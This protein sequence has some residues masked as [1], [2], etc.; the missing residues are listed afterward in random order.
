MNSISAIAVACVGQQ[1]EV[2]PITS[3]Q[4]DTEHPSTRSK[5]PGGDGVMPSHGGFPLKS[6]AQARMRLV[7]NQIIQ[8][9]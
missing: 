5:V 1:F 3:K 9:I 2:V 6:L 8:I 4:R 7:H